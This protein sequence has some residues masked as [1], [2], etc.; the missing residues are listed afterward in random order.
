M[1]YV[2]STL[3]NFREQEFISGHSSSYSPVNNQKVAELHN[4]GD[5]ISRG[6][7]RAAADDFYKALEDEQSETKITRWFRRNNTV[8]RLANSMGLEG[9]SFTSVDG[10]LLGTKGQAFAIPGENRFFYSRKDWTPGV[11]AHELGHLASNETG[12]GQATNYL[13]Q[14]GGLLGALAL[15]VA[16]RKSKGLTRKIFGGGAVASAVA[17]NLGTYLQEVDAWRHG[18]KALDDLKE[19]S[20]FYDQKAREAADVTK[21]KAL[22][23][24]ALGG[25]ASTAVGLGAAGGAYKLLG[26]SARAK[27]IFR[28]SAKQ[29]ALGA[30]ILAL[31]A[32]SPLGTWAMAK[33]LSGEGQAKDVSSDDIAIWAGG[34]DP[35]TSHL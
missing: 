15:G 18:D 22:G 32:G 34:E 23:T 29:K 14:Q 28:G 2:E 13:K 7:A 17:P 31:T 6:V 9:T 26:D 20:W 1:R 19:T 8:R 12:Y 30:G 27:D 33:Q 21:S 10:D 16:A 4:H 5:L 35:E 24:Y 11:V 3:D 25:L